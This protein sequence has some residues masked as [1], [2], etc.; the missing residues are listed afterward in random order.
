[1]VT[2]IVKVIRGFLTIL[3]EALIGWNQHRAMSHAG[4]LAFFTIF[5]LAPLI[6]LTV[7]IAGGVYAEE[8]IEWR[9]VAGIEKQAGEPAAT[10]V[11]DLIVNVNDLPHSRLAT[12]ISVLLL[13]WGG[14]AMFSQLQ[15]SINEMWGIAPNPERI[16]HSLRAMLRSRL[17]SAG[18]VLGV[19]YLVV[20]ALTLSTLLAMIPMRWLSGPA[21]AMDD[22][23]PFIRVWS[24]PVVYMLLFAFTFKM[25]PQATVRW[26]DV[27]VGSAL[28][29]LLFWIGN[30]FIVYYLSKSVFLSIY[31]ATSSVIVF[32]IWVYYSAWI[33]LFGANFIRVYTDKFGKPIVPYPYMAMQYTT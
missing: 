16:R 7:S 8:D 28:T 24:S 23:V 25:L 22:L 30:K 29:S 12:G 14:S 32:L 31:G 6:T 15:T 21:Q 2:R 9:I 3:R 33:V 4:A 26:R 10:Y 18:L 5:S 1:M 27:W 11:H 20:A 13:I 17:M 19:G